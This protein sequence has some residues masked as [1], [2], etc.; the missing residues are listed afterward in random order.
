MANSG[1]ISDKVVRFVRM[2]ISEN[3]EQTEEWEEEPEE[4]FPQDCCGQSCRP[5]VFDMHH[6]DVVRWAKECAKRIPHNGSSLYSHLCP[7]DEESNSGSTE[8]VFSPNEY[9]F[10]IASFL[11]ALPFVYKKKFRE[12][13]LLEITPMSPDTNLYK[14]AIT[15]GKP[16]VPIGSHLRTSSAEKCSINI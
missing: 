5:C 9:R 3:K 8:T 13:Q 1:S 7:E 2:Y 6:D 15:Q 14:F 11:I 4:P 12:F 16:N 10:C